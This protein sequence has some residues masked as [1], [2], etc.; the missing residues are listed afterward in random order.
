M[1]THL[2]GWRE[3]LVEESFQLVS[4]KKIPHKAAKLTS[5]APH[6][7]EKTA[8]RDLFDVGADRSMVLK[9]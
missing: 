9:T 2:A 4:L 7:K 6:A 8:I 3:H 5:P 1:R